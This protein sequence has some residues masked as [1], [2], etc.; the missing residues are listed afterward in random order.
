[1]LIH[2]LIF[3]DF[4]S[5]PLDAILGHIPYPSGSYRVCLFVQIVLIEDMSLVLRFLN[6]IMF[7]LNVIPGNTSYMSGSSRV[8]WIV[9]TGLAGMLSHAL[10]F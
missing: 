4:I 7:M 10:I 2:A 6:F 3:R 8:C 9:Q 1:M 5:S